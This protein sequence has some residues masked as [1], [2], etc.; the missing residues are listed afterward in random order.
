MAAY[1]PIGSRAPRLPII[2]S[3]AASTL[4]AVI[5]VNPSEIR[6]RSPDP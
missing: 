4:A 5:S 2:L 6:P 3:G 1:V